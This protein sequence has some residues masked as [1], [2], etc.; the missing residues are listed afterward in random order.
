[1][2]P[3]GCCGPVYSRDVKIVSIRYPG[4]PGIESGS[5]RN[6]GGWV[7]LAGPNG[8]GKSRLLAHISEEVAALPRP[9]K[10]EELQTH[11]A[12]FRN[13]LRQTPGSSAAALWEANLASTT[14]A[15]DRQQR[16]VVEGGHP[17]VVPFSPRGALS[18]D[19]HNLAPAQ[20]E[21]C[22]DAAETV[23]IVGL[24][25]N[26]L[27]RIQRLQDLRWSATHQ[28]SL[29]DSETRGRHSS[30]YD[31]LNRLVESLVGA[32]GRDDQDRAT[33]F[34]LPLGRAE[35]SD[36]Q[37]VLLQLAVAISAQADSLKEII[38][39][40]DEPELHLH[41]AAL[42]DFF[43]LLSERAQGCQ[44][45]VAT[46]S[47]HALSMAD[48]SQIYFM[49]GGKP[50]RSGREPERVLAGLLGGEEEAGRLAE[51]L[52]LPARLGANRFAAECLL[53]PISVDT[54]AGD[55]Q[56]N[57]IRA[58]IETMRVDD[59]PLRILDFGA[60]R[61]RTVRNLT[62]VPGETGGL[63]VDLYAYEMDPGCTTE[64]EEAMASA[65][66]DATGRVLTALT[67]F[68]RFDDD[69]VDIVIMCN[70][71]HEIP[72]RDWVEL[73]GEGGQLARVM[74]PQ[75][76]LLIVE[77]YEIPYGEKAYQNGFL[78]LD[79]PQ[80]RSLFGIRVDGGEGGGA[81]E[82]LAARDGRL[83][84]HMLPAASLTSITADSRKAAITNLLDRAKE[85]VKELRSGDASYRNGRLHGLWS[86]LMTNA[87]LALSEM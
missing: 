45:W 18:V 13:A 44:I 10:I 49:N 66:Q 36:G 83:K 68:A 70:V 85:R 22:S 69:S 60:G 52:S 24:E 61:G 51:F 46:H 34:G 11:A 43:R 67:E 65:C 72:P 48:P 56:T 1:M 79:E 62:S 80:L 20:L 28:D 54:G 7:Y 37:A 39:F 19:P 3:R 76:K 17:V 33:L 29:I 50:R 78:L 40:L 4:V 82:I 71:L 63:D 42:R 41:P 30:R 12:A 9:E 6:L 5:L 55:P 8:A 86:Q 38:L 23:G 26:C 81:Y 27:A 47:V 25:L 74:G 16:I 87:T 15:L 73:F 35:L 59:K 75:A 58:A 64:L 53:P 21:A 84:A 14:A 32:L 31:A 2:A 57:Q 77:D